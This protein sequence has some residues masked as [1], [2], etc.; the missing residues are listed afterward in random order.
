MKTTSV[1]SLAIIITLTFAAQCH[2]ADTSHPNIVFVLADDL[3]YGDLRCYNADSKVPTPNLDRLAEG[4]MRF[5]DAHSGAAVCSP[6]RYGLLTGRHFLRRPNWIEGILNRCLIDE[7]QLTLPKYLKAN[8]Y[9]TAC[10]GKWHLGQTWFNQKGEPSGPGPRTDF[11]RP[12]KG[13]PNDQGFD[14]FFGMNGTAV[15]AP[16]VLMENRLVTEVPTEQGPKKGRP[17]ARSHRPVDVMPRTTKSALAYIDTAINQRDGQPFFVYYAMT[18]IHTPI[19][20]APKYKGT[21]AA[22]DYGDFVFQVDDTVGQLVKKLEEHGL[23]DDTLFVFSS[24]NGSH[25]RASERQGDGPGSVI[26]KYGHKANGDWRGLKGDGYE[27]GHRVPFIA[28]WPGRVPERTRCD[29]LITLEDFFATCSAIVGQPLPENSAQDSFNILPYLKGDKVAS[30]IRPYA[31][32]ST[33]YGKPVIR[34]GSWVLFPFLEGGGPHEK[35][36]PALVEGGPQ[37]QLFDLSKDPGQ[38]NNAWLDHPDI[39][40][41]LTRL[42]AEHNRR[43]RSVG[44]ER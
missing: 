7:E 11:T 35:N 40:K 24:D 38:T 42:H 6:T 4:G 23:A 17:M 2:S 8:G 16:L 22:S 41:E 30:D 21:S 5:T 9:H 3:G 18:A 27:G 39:V 34:K 19:V 31:V 15:G 28:R 44:I 20:P 36:L 25:G 14:Y 43:G 10:F 1:L 32:L 12:T 37:G 26:R 29:E 33:F 13:G